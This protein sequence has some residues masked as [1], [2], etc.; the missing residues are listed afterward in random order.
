MTVDLGAMPDDT[1]KADGLD[2]A[3]IGVDADYRRPGVLVVNSWGRYWVDGPK[4]H[5][6]PDGT[7]WC[8]AD[9]LERKLLREQD[10]WV[11]GDDEG[12]PPKKLDLRII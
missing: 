6:Q 7:F 3:I 2:D 11:F 5:D 10:S 1:M 4:R 9:V 12:F 8:D